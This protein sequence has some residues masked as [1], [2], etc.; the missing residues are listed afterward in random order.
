MPE[1]PAPEQDPVVS[2]SLSGPLLVSSLIVFLTLVW[3]LADETYFLRPWKRYQS[4]FVTLY[5]AALKKLQ[6]VQA[7]GEEAIRKS[8]ACQKLD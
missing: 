7:R 5:T 3:A 2:K 6:P 4:R 8:A 1:N